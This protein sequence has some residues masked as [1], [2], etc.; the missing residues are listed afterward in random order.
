MPAAN[1]SLRVAHRVGQEKSLSRTCIFGGAPPPT[2]V[3]LTVV[4]KLEDFVA[5]AA[6]LASL[7]R[8]SGSSGLTLS[9]RGPFTD[10]MAVHGTASALPLCKCAIFHG[11]YQMPDDLIKAMLRDAEAC[12]EGVNSS[13]ARCLLAHSG[14][15][16]SESAFV[17][18]GTKS[19]AGSNVCPAGHSRCLAAHGENGFV[20]DA[21]GSTARGL[22]RN[23]R[24][25]YNRV[26]KAGSR[27]IR[28]LIANHLAPMNGFLVHDHN[29]ESE[30]FPGADTLRGALERLPSRAAYINHAGFAGDLAPNTWSINMVRNP[31][32]RASSSYY[33]VRREDAIS[34]EKV[35]RLQSM[36]ECGCWGLE[37]D[38][39]VIVTVEQQCTHGVL[40][41]K[42][43]R[44]FCE[45]EESTC[46]VELA[47][48]R[49]RT[50]Y[51]VIGLTE[52]FDLTL[53]LLEHA[54]PSWFQNASGIYHASRNAFTHPTPWYNNLTGTT[55]TGVSKRALSLLRGWP[56]YRD[57]QL[58]YEEAVRR[59]WVDAVQA[60]VVQ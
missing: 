20:A 18:V 24:L 50:R 34:L 17:Y 11:T 8:Q 57:E 60:G 2:E 28:T 1:G 54:L 4:G 19:F 32:D 53:R 6:T 23:F 33:W 56:P 46:T 36:G 55:T 40:D 3:A 16:R 7:Q 35:E 10:R 31:L 52:E 5:V 30:Y 15:L 13:A 9:S 21:E 14:D 41:F 12:T 59:F 45:P 39:C 43:W 37:F 44:Y 49:M 26:D 42:Q 38:Q 22:H 58:F 51:R 48:H 29:I 25:V 47:I 27:T